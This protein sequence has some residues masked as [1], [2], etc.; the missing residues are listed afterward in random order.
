MPRVIPITRLSTPQ[1]G[2]G[3]GQGRLGG[4]SKTKKLH[5]LNFTARFLTKYLLF[6]WLAKGLQNSKETILNFLKW[7]RSRIFENMFVLISVLA[8]SPWVFAEK[9]GKNE[10]ILEKIEKSVKRKDLEWRKDKSEKQKVLREKESVMKRT[11]FKWMLG[12]QVT[13]R[14]RLSRRRDKRRRRGRQR[15]SRETL[16]RLGKL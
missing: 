6:F 13:H 16:G 8:F 2:S 9:I 11:I 4:A 1:L 10:K 14:Q 12:L 5:N 7:E 15:N 3:P